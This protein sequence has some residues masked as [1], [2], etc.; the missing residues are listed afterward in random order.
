MGEKIAE[1][2]RRAYD[3]GEYETAVAAFSETRSVWRQLGDKRGEASAL[4]DLGV[5]HQRMG[6]LADAQMAYEE[7]L[8]LFEELGDDDGRAT[9]MGNLAT[10]M[11]R[12]G[13]ADQAE[14]LLQQAADMFYQLGKEDYEADTLRLLAQVQMQRGGWLDSLITYNRAMSRMERLTPLQS[15]LRLLS[16]L[17][18]RII[19]VRQ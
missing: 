11:R 2:G 15:F 6:N 7:A 14:S 4:V 13:A 12:R 18:L 16:N 10:L 5:A 8:V 17:F 1:R 19:G 9:V 3:R